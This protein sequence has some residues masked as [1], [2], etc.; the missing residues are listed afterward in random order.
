MRRLAAAVCLSLL[1]LVPQAVAQATC[2]YAPWVGFL[3]YSGT[4]SYQYCK[5]ST[6]I[7]FSAYLYYAQQ[8][9][10]SYLW[11]FGDG[12]TATTS[13]PTTTHQFATAG[14]HLVRVTASNTHGSSSTSAYVT[15]AN[16]AFSIGYQYNYW[17][18]GSSALV[19]VTRD[20]ST[21]SATVDYSTIDSTAKAGVN[22]TAT[23][24]TLTFN[25]GE[26]A[27]SF[28]I[29]LLR[30][31][32]YTGALSLTAKIS[33]PG[34][35]YVLGDSISTFVGIS[36]V[37]PP[38]TVGFS[39]T[40]YTI[41]E[42]GGQTPITLTR[43][44]DMAG[45]VIASYTVYPGPVLGVNGTVTFGPNETTKSFNVTPVNDDVYTGT[46]S[47]SAY[48]S[49]NTGTTGNYYA[50]IYV[51]DDE[52][53]PTLTVNDVSMAEGDSGTANMTFTATLSSPLTQSRSLYYY[54]QDQSATAG[55]DYTAASNSIYFAPGE[56]TKTFTVPIIGDTAVETNETFRVN[57]QLCCG[58]FPV[59]T[60][61]HAIG[62]ILN[63]DIGIGPPELTIARGDTGTITL[64][65]AQPVTAA[66]AIAVSSSSPTVASVP[67]SITVAAGSQA[68]S[69]EVKGLAR[70]GA[71]IRATLPASLGGAT[72][73][74]HVSVFEPVALTVTP[75]SLTIP[76][77]STGVAT[78]SL[79][80]PVNDA[81]LITVTP[82]STTA[83]DVPAIVTIPAGGSATLSVKALKQQPAVVTLTLPGAYGSA[84]SVLP[85]EITDALTTAFISQIAPPNG[86]AAGGTAVSISGGNF[87]AP[88]TLSFGGAA[89]TSVTVA[90]ATSLTAVT[91]AHGAGTVDVAVTCGTAPAFTFKNGF[92][93]T[94]A[95]TA[96]SGISPAF[97]SVAGGTL[98][99]LTGSSFRSGCGV[100]LDGAAAHGVTLES[101]TAILAS[102]PQHADGTVDVTLR[103]G[104]DASKLA[105]AYTYT[106]NDDPTASIAS[107]EPLFA[108]PG[109]PVTLTGARFRTTDH[110][111]FGSA[112]AAVLATTPETHVVRVPDLPLGKV[113]I[114][115]TDVNGR[116]ITTGPVFN[117]LEPV[118]PQITAIHPPS[119]AA[120]SEI[121]LDGKGF[122]APYTFGLGEHALTIVSLAY[123]HAIVRVP[124]PFDA[125]TQP[126]TVLNALH[127]IASVG[128]QFEVTANGPAIES[129]TPGCAT[130]GGTLDVVIRGSGF[131]AGATVTVGGNDAIAVTVDD[132]TTIHATLAPGAVGAATLTVRNADG[133]SATVSDAL[134]YVSPYDADGGCSGRARPIHH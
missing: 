54:T 83:L 93:Y 61:D 77:G 47:T 90:S 94:S 11:D 58:E 51:K 64:R 79:T 119:G 75:S 87:A 32:V 44:G 103:C 66:T 55:T 1:A 71:T 133:T 22:Y 15:V 115:L 63:D 18:E 26:A 14:K 108:A 43:S 25:D 113:E 126:V 70:G 27:K 10:D 78:L 9:C 31:H 7:S 129:I 86:P 85:V 121:A 67:S 107:I 65:L 59:L 98:V 96:L 112:P 106:K 95:A 122:R 104:S 74:S 81:T 37:D 105:A 131:A 17:T 117:V 111:A 62:T 12:T 134:R 125:G 5:M 130:T 97:G 124:R 28:S 40:S 38:P 24:G 128:P 101:P 127:Q 33:N 100:W 2:S 73:S 114:T 89:A 82:S 19:Q 34:N 21:G 116:L 39:Q 132:A 110:I 48:V 109:Q 52:P 16:G 35:G 53:A 3:N 123:D 92:T 46:R 45:T 56:T 36:D 102:T 88:C 13:N 49:V 118:S 60:R 84:S 69:I 72:L 99:R 91:P 42:N 8:S 80:P 29:P 41:N 4:C 50:Q 68:A 30:D 76:V 20:V 120:G 57:L 23:S 6:P